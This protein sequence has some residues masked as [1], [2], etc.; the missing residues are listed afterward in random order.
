MKTLRV[1]EIIESASATSPRKGLQVFEVVKNQIE[2]GET[3]VLSF[4]GVEDVVTA[5]ANAAIGRLYMEMSSD[6][7]NAKLKIED[8]RDIWMSK[9]NLAIKLATDS[10]TRD[11]HNSNI[12]ELMES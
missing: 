12:D 1:K 2:K 5:F 6:L 8:A 7:L 4:S 11:A 10:R 3:V 9:I